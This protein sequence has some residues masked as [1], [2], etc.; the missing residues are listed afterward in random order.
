MT[1]L[2]IAIA[3]LGALL[4]AGWAAGFLLLA[5]G[6]LSLD[7]GWGRSVH[8]L[9]PIMVRI[10]APRELVFEIIEAPYTGRAPS[11]SGVEVLAR[12]DALVVAAHHTRVHFYTARTVEAVEFEPPARVGFRHLT[13]PVPH[14][15]EQFTLEESDGTTALRYEGEVGIDF[16]GLGRLA[17]RHW[18]RPQWERTVREHL[19][20]VKRRAEQRSAAQRSRQ[21]REAAG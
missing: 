20:E 12:S 17:A 16:F 15:V 7:L 18:V 1:G 14:A 13:G 2:W 4:I 5:M 9:G 11:G 10:D 19:V 8:P 21:D 3:V 6:R